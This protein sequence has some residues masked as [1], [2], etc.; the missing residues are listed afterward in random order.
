MAP[1]DSLAGLV[2]KRAFLEAL[3]RSHCPASAPHPRNPDPQCCWPVFPGP[4]A[5]S[6][7]SPTHTLR[8]QLFPQALPASV[9]GP[10]QSASFSA[11]RG[12]RRQR[13]HRAALQVESRPG[14]GGPSGSRLRGSRWAGGGPPPPN[15][16]GPDFRSGGRI[17]PLAARPRP[18]PTPAVT[19]ARRGDLTRQHGGGGRLGQRVGAAAAA[20]TAGS[21]VQHLPPPLSLLRVAG[22]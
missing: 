2:L 20:A 14:E 18:A 13:Y 3:S 9:V 12:R 16:C 5:P 6:A 19:E 15:L 8:L 22:A 10:S 11:A 4:D 21:C 7:G 1:L 17:R